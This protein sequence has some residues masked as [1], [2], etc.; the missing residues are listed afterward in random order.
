MLLDMLPIIGLPEINQSQRTITF[1]PVAA[2]PYMLSQ[3]WLVPRPVKQTFW[4]QWTSYKFNSNNRLQ[5]YANELPL[6]TSTA[7]YSQTAHPIQNPIEFSGPLG[8]QE[9]GSPLSDG[10]STLSFPTTIC[11]WDFRE[12][13]KPPKAKTRLLGSGQTNWATRARL[14]TSTSRSRTPVP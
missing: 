14:S 2:K 4:I 13:S 1:L 3:I 10:H 12:N 8:P 5:L 11:K 7:C 6:K 9:T